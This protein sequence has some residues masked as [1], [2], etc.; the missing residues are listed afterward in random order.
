MAKGGMYI[1]TFMALKKRS[2]DLEMECKKEGG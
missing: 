2:F 1:F